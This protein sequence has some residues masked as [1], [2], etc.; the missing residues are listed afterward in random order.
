MFGANKIV[1]L[2]PQWSEETQ[3]HIKQA[4]G[5]ERPF[6]ATGIVHHLL[7]QY[8][9]A[10]I[11][12]DLKVTGVYFRNEVNH[13][14]RRYGLE[15]TP[16]VFRSNF[17]GLWNTLD[18]VPQPIDVPLDGQI[19]R[20][21]IRGMVQRDKGAINVPSYTFRMVNGLVYSLYGYDLDLQGVYLPSE[22]P[23]VVEID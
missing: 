16:L 1:R 10:A 12:V 9:C 2:Q 3:L 13:R 8:D 15:E 14:V 19:H 11:C 21:A 7:S 4:D 20:L 6:Y 18:L 5:L 17:Q 22:T 23:Q